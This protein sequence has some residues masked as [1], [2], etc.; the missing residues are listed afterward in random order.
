M[1]KKLLTVSAL[2]VG[3]VGGVLAGCQTYDFEPVQPLVL[4]STNMGQTISA[5]ALT[6]NMMLLVDKSGSMSQAVGSSTRM[7]EMKS[8]MRTFLSTKGSVAR[9]G[10]SIFP[11]DAQCGAT[12]AVT[13]PLATAEDSAGLQAH[14]STV[15]S[16]I[17]KLSPAGGTPTSI[18][19][20]FL[21]ASVPALKDAER[22]NFVLLLTDGEPNCNPQNPNVGGSAA[23]NCTASTCVTGDPLQCLDRDASVSRVRELGQAG[24]KTIV[25]GFGA[26]VNNTGSNGYLTLNAMAEAGGFARSCATDANACGADTCDATTK[27]CSRRFYSAGNA[28]E[29]AQA[30]ERISSLLPGDP[31]IWV[32][33]HPEQKPASTDYMV[34]LVNDKALE[35]GADTWRLTDRGVEFQGATCTQIKSSTT[36]DPVKVEIRVLNLP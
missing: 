15:L 9:M 5:R 28:T 33:D 27:L 35:P 22:A 2:T 13:V 19:L 29:L 21:N 11:T 18:S 14:A 24:V 26:D 31:C 32:F 12:T 30:L 10:L 17:D 36:R 3:V 7:A 4:S 6:P 8:A 34:V 16:E 23:C 1:L 20:N 25:I